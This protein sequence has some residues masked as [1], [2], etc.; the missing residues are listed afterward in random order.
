MYLLILG[1]I[2]R[3][4]HPLM[5]SGVWAFIGILFAASGFLLFGGPA[6]LSILT[7]SE[8]WRGFWLL[9]KSPASSGDAQFMQAWVFLA[10]LYF[11]LVIVGSGMLL[12]RQRQLT[13]IYNVE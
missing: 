10:I 3:R 5:V 1:G 8:R 9:G 4:Q 11:A 2:N 6:I 7:M 13:S 12:W